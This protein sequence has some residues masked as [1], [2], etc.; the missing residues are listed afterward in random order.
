MWLLR[1]RSFW[2]VL[3]SGY[4]QYA[5]VGYLL[6]GLLLVLLALAL[7]L[8]RRSWISGGVVLALVGTAFQL[9]LLAPAY[10]GSHPHGRPALTVLSLNLRLGNGDAAVA[11]DLVR[12]EKPQIVVLEEITA[13]ELARFTS[14]GLTAA[15]PYSAGGPRGAASGTMVFSAYP[16][17]EVV[18]VPL[19]HESLRLRVAAPSP[20]WLVAVHTGQPINEP[21][22]WRADWGVLNQIVPALHGSV[23][24]AG[25]FNTTLDHAPMRELL[26]KGFADAARTANSGWQP[27]WPRQLGMVAIDHVLT[28]GSYAAISTSTFKVPDTDHRALVARL[29]KV[30]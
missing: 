1:P 22:D 13:P 29:A 8:P 18:Q 27:T 2:F 7:G 17:S 3:I 21:G 15:L 6:S 25:D 5:L 30:N 9:V 12:R 20:F 24:V 26:G 14:D 23:I 16:L 11:M 19:H 4:V 28:R 10:L